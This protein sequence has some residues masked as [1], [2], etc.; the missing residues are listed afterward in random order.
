MAFKTGA[1]GAAFTFI[2]VT[3]ILR[4]NHAALFGSRPVAHT[5][6]YLLIYL[7]PYKHICH[8]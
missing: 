6:A 4:Q 2:K 3:Q 8:Q 5:T 7:T 1:K